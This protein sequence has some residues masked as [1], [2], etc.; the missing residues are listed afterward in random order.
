MSLSSR[1][2]PI[3]AAIAII[4]ACAPAPAALAEDGFEA[5]FGAGALHG[6]SG[7]SSQSR[8]VIEAWHH[9]KQERAE[10]G[11][12]R[13]GQAESRAELG[14]GAGAMLQATA[15]FTVLGTEGIEA[16]AFHLGIEPL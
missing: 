11:L 15:G 12:R 4:Q 9:F 8:F 10:F 13:Y 3:L 14:Q 16:V 6:T 1:L 5:P 7:D 2:F